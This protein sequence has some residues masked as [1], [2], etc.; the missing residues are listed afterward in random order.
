LQ[1]LALRG[2]WAEFSRVWVT[3]DKRD[4]RSLLADEPVVF[5]HG[6]T[7]RNFGLLA[8]KNLLLNLR[9]ALR[10][11]RV[12]RPKVVLT[13]GAG[14]AVP[15]A[16]IGRALGARVVYVESLTRI[17]RPSLSCRLIAPVASRIYAQWPELTE[18]VPRSRY[19]G[20]VVS[21]S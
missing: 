14:V 19:V 7:N 20:S 6:P 21:G 5:A 8:V 10:L 11:L 15:F 13:T 16:W 18:A 4:A 3:F 1:L 9:T 2:A 17:E 12:A